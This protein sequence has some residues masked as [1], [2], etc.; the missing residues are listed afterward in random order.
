M[1]RK[2]RL[3]SLGKEVQDEAFTVVLGSQQ[4]CPQEWQQWRAAMCLL[5][6]CIFKV[7]NQ[8]LVAEAPLLCLSLCSWL[9]LGVSFIVH[10]KAAVF[11]EVWGIVSGQN[12]KKS[13][14][15]LHPVL[16][17]ATPVYLCMHLT[18]LAHAGGKPSSEL[19][20]KEDPSVLHGM[21][22]DQGL[23]SEQEEWIKAGRQQRSSKFAFL[24]L[25][26]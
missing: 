14:F 8:E 11:K 24:P 25:D 19:V 10:N 5:F 23:N 15:F 21:Q 2:L 1:A 18:R 3:S 22:G 9:P 6:Q 17:A 20:R 16:S 7:W 12:E 4:L 26:G 13:V